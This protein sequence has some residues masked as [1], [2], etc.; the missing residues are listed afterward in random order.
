MTGIMNLP[1]GSRGMLLAE[2]ARAEP[3]LERG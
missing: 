3:E 2:H 1:R